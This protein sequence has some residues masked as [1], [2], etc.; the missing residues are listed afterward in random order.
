MSEVFIIKIQLQETIERLS[1]SQD[2]NKQINI[3]SN[4][5]FYKYIYCAANWFQY[6]L[7]EDNSGLLFP[8]LGKSIKKYKENYNTQKYQ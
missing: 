1:F 3:F 8:G 4:E 6:M 2:K 5:K 7:K